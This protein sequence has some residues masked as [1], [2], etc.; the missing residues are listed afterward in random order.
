M[1]SIAAL[2]PEMISSRL[3]NSLVAAVGDLAGAVG[4]LAG[5]PLS[6]GSMFMKAKSNNVAW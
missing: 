3:F 1:F 6:E 4:D 5:A 2:V